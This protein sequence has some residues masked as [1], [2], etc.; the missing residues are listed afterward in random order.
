MSRLIRSRISHLESSLPAGEGG[1]RGHYIEPHPEI[2]LREHCL[3]GCRHIR[4]HPYHIRLACCQALHLL[5]QQFI[6]FSFSLC[7]IILYCNETTLKSIIASPHQQH[8]RR[9][10]TFLNSREPPLLGEVGGGL[11]PLPPWGGLGWGFT[12][13]PSSDYSGNP[14]TPTGCR[15]PA[16]SCMSS[17]GPWPSTHPAVSAAYRSGALY[18]RGWHPRSR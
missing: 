9:F 1:G 18:P 4:Q 5:A 11:V 14:R 17:Q 15:P 2:F 6:S 10:L 13:P 16:P 8:P 7:H 12:V 3:H